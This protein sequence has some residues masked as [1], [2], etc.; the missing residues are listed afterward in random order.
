MNII[1]TYVKLYEW[2]TMKLSKN[3][4]LCQGQYISK[5]NEHHLKMV[6]KLWISLWCLLVYLML[7]CYKPWRI[8]MENHLNKLWIIN[9]PEKKW[10]LFVGCA[11][12]QQKPYSLVHQ[13][14]SCTPS[15]TRTTVKFEEFATG[16]FPHFD[17]RLVYEIMFCRLCLDA[18]ECNIM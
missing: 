2:K 15:D 16:D 10:R 7:K 9:F 13:P 4:I 12:V 1:Y 8:N 6:D 18:Y 5:I 11:I 17:W 14:P 3:S